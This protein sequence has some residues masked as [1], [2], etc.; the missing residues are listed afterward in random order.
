MSSILMLRGKEKITYNPQ[1]ADFEALVLKA[2][3]Q[4]QQS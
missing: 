2:Q 4:N 3:L 1:L